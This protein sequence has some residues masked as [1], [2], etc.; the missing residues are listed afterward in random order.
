M[1]VRLTPPVGCAKPSAPRRQNW[2]CPKAK[3]CARAFD[4]AR[5]GTSANKENSA[6]ALRPWRE[7]LQKKGLSGKFWGRSAR[8]NPSSS[9][10]DGMHRAAPL[11]ESPRPAFRCVAEAPP[12][13]ALPPP[14]AAEEAG[15]KPPSLQAS[16]P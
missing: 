15:R 11:A 4:R 6:R 10:D 14:R 3:A 8:V 7:S 5:A 9:A 13:R 1:Q 12:A 16:A 2:K